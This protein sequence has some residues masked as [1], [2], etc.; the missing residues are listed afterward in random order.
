MSA[1]GVVGKAQRALTKAKAMAAVKARQITAP[2]FQSIG[3]AQ[4]K[5]D[6]FKAAFPS[7][8]ASMNPA[9]LRGLGLSQTAIAGKF[10]SKVNLQAFNADSFSKLKDLGNQMGQVRVPSYSATKSQ[11]LAKAS[12]TKTQISNSLMSK[13]PL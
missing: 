6:A 7:G 10:M 3:A 4:S 13:L 1:A 5:I 8:V 9:T 2:V 11:F 12:N